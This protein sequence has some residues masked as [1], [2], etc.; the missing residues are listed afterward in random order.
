M[1]G[2]NSDGAAMGSDAYYSDNGGT[3]FTQ[4]ST[5]D[6]HESGLKDFVWPFPGDLADENDFGWAYHD[7]TANAISV[8]MYDATAATITET[9]IAGTYVDDFQQYSSGALG[10]QSDGT[11][12]WAVN[13]GNAN[14]Y[15]CSVYH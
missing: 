2:Y 12:I 9:A 7:I 8:K 11:A 10:M 3:S 14:H 15:F 4:L 6:P 13:D 1:I 5:A